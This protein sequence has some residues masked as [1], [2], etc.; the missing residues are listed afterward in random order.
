VS[1]LKHEFRPI[2]LARTLLRP[3]SPRRAGDHGARRERQQQTVC[4]L[5]REKART[6]IARAGARFELVRRSEVFHVIYY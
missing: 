4:E 2:S 3:S 5:A 1:R 6:A